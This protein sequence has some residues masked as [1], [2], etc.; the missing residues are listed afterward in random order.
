[1][2]IYPNVSVAH[3]VMPFFSVLISCSET[4]GTAH[5]WLSG[6][7]LAHHLLSMKLILKIDAEHYSTYWIYFQSHSV[8]VL[9]FGFVPL[10]ER[11][12]NRKRSLHCSRSV[13]AFDVSE[14]HRF[15]VSTRCAPNFLFLSVFMSL[16]LKTVEAVN[17][18]STR[19]VPLKQ[20]A[21]L[22]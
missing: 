16:L 9:Q 2:V 8:T 17:K 14:M 22:L 5:S 1:M 12:S 6:M 11:A 20:Y 7:P 18:P 3:S 15:T 4:P 13:S 10:A 19:S 21:E